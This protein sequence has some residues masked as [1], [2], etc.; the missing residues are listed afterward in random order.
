[1]IPRASNTT[2]KFQPQIIIIIIVMATSNFVQNTGEEDNSKKVGWRWT[3]ALMS[4]CGNV[5][6]AIPIKMMCFIA[7]E[8]GATS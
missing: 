8:L 4:V 3:A 2:H 1:V 6:V 5:G 7:W